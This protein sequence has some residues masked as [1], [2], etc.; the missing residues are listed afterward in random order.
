MTKFKTMEEFENFKDTAMFCVCGKLL[1]GFHMGNCRKLQKIE[2]QIRLNK[3]KEAK[4]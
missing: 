3:E 1:T 2:R 4:P